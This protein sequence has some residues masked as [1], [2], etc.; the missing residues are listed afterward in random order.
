MSSTTPLVSNTAATL[1]DCAW[2]DAANSLSVEWTEMGAKF[3]T[4]SSCAH[5]TRVVD[6]VAYKSAPLERVLDVSGNQIYD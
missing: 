4:C 5:R 6:G 1:P 3:C 2:C